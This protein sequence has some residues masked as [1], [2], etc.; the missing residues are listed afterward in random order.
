[1]CHCMAVGAHGPLAFAA[2]CKAIPAHTPSSTQH[3]DDEVLLPRV[4]FPLLP[5]VIATAAALGNEDV[6]RLCNNPTLKGESRFQVGC[7]G[8]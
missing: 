7:R 3:K 2:D 8:K 1:M 4:W 5:C 6:K